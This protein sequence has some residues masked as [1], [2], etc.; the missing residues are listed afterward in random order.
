MI[1]TE[2]QMDTNINKEISEKDQSADDIILNLNKQFSIFANKILR[3]D[4]Q[5]S[6]P[7]RDIGES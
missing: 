1:L 2:M 4:K 5:Q 6:V 7:G 3:P